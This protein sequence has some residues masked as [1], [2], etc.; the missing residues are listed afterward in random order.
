MDSVIYIRLGT[1]PVLLSAFLFL[2]YVT[3]TDRSLESLH[4]L[5]PKSPSFLTILFDQTRSAL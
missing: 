4:H 3:L 5:L 2:T 1:L